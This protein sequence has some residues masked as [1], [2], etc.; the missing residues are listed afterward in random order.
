MENKRVRERRCAPSM[1]MQ[2]CRAR[3]HDTCRIGKCACCQNGSASHTHLACTRAA[4]M[5]VSVT[6]LPRM[7]FDAQRS[8]AAAREPCST[9]A[10]SARAHRCAVGGGNARC[11]RAALAAGVR[12]GG[13]PARGASQRASQA[14]RTPATRIILSAARAPSTSLVSSALRGL[15]GTPR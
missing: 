3:M 2:R 5:T 11:S 1:C 13:I 14:G 7:T 12:I 6:D 8:T 15:S 10:Q 4:I 9:A